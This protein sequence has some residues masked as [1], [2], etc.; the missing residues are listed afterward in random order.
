VFNPLSAKKAKEIQSE[1][2]S[3]PARALP[4]GR[5]LLSLFTFQF[6]SLVVSE[7]YFRVVYIQHVA[8]KWLNL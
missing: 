3:M 4:S 2:D 5:R 8:L 7:T 6:Q 1:S